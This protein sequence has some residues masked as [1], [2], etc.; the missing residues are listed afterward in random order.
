MNFK[1]IIIGSET[2]DPDSIKLIL[3]SDFTCC[4]SATYH[5][6]VLTAIS[7]REPCIL[8]FYLGTVAN[9]EE[10]YLKL[11]RS[12]NG[13]ADF[14]HKT[15]LLCDIDESEIAYGLCR[16]HVFSDY[17][18]TNTVHDSHR[19]KL[20]LYQ[21][22]KL[23]TME[24]KIKST[25]D[26]SVTWL[27]DISEYEQ[28]AETS[29]HI[30]DELQNAVTKE[31]SN[32]SSDITDNLSTMTKDFNKYKQYIARDK[33]DNFNSEFKKDACLV[34][35]ST[36]TGAHE[37]VNQFLS[38][39][40]KNYSRELEKLKTKNLAV[41]AAA[42]EIL[43]QMIMVVVSN[44]EQ[45]QE[46]SEILRQ[47]NF[48]VVMANSGKHALSMMVDKMPSLVLLESELPG[49]KG[50]AF[51]RMA[52][53][54]CEQKVSPFIFLAKDTTR[55]NVA[56]MLNMGAVDIISLPFKKEAM[57]EKIES[58]IYYSRR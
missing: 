1:I 15:I 55:K 47:N 9:A 57:L 52:G 8:I 49:M 18:T 53:I 24:E 4:L 48:S 46:I 21:S 2:N 3:E 23:L 7:N 14:P 54:L 43:N 56:H 30:T 39:A 41:K 27:S 34:V 10:Y 38:R 28:H 19:L 32:L 11:Y 37:N 17:I 35:E 44:K 13:L 51:I 45:R 29:I 25:S 6:E 26:I 31:Y 22:I 5:K 58:T 33:V 40:R 42:E 12:T 36:I 20:S 50:E 16:E